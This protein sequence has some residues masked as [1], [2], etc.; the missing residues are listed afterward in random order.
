[1]KKFSLFLIILFVLVSC[2]S[3]NKTHADIDKPHLEVIQIEFTSQ[4]LSSIIT[5]IPDKS[6][7]LINERGFPNFLKQDNIDNI[8]LLPDFEYIVIDSVRMN[9]IITF[10]KEVLKE[11]REKSLPII[12]SL[13]DSRYLLLA[14]II[15]INRDSFNLYTANIDYKSHNF[16]K[17]KYNLMIEVLN[18]II[19]NSKDSL[20]IEYYEFTNKRLMNIKND[21]L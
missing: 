14:N 1:M 6:Y 2:I 15:I 10:S 7:L 17:S 13:I 18:G 11:K 4:S 19:E 9:K 12:N 3:K 8:K 5:I 20:S 21:M 16:S